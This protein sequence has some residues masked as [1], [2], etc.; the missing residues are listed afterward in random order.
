MTNKP[1]ASQPGQVVQVPAICVNCRHLDARTAADI[2]AV[3]GKGQTLRAAIGGDLAVCQ[4]PGVTDFVTGGTARRPKCR[5][6][7]PDGNCPLFQP[8]RVS[9]PNQLKL[10]G[11]PP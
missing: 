3:V 7:N 8:R 5:D 10:P 2:Q 6:Q 11:T 9:E 4:A 1:F